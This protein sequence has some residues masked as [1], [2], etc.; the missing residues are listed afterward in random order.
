MEVPTKSYELGGIQTKY[1]LKKIEIRYAQTQ[2]DLVKI[3][4]T[5]I[6]IAGC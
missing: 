2:C 3:T 5:A 4:T 1:S 6:P